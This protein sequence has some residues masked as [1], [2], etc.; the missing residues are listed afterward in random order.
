MA[1]I[2]QALQNLKNNQAA[3]PLGRKAV[4]DD[5]GRIIGCRGLAL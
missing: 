1:T 2:K 3:K 4:R 5:A